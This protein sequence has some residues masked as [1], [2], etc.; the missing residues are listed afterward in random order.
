MTYHLSSFQPNFH[1]FV[2]KRLLIHRGLVLCGWKDENKL[3]KFMSSKLD[4]T[5]AEG[6]LW[7]SIKTCICLAKLSVIEVTACFGIQINAS[8]SDVWIFHFTHNKFKVATVNHVL[9]AHGYSRK[10][11]LKVLELVFVWWFEQGPPTIGLLTVV[12]ELVV[13]K[14]FWIQLFR[15]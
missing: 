9:I 5:P 15:E 13:E 8:L 10:I 4:S 3:Q 11:Q 12:V 7:K 14:M 2:Q 1:V 6:C